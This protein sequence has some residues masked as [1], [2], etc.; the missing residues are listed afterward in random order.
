MCVIYLKKN[1]TLLR[2][3]PVFLRRVF[4]AKPNTAVHGAANAWTFRCADGCRETEA[5][6]S[7]SG[8]PRCGDTVQPGSTATPISSSHSARLL[9]KRLVGR[10]C[11]TRPYRIATA[12]YSTHTL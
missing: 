9:P 5:C 1:T 8:V 11:T 12:R 10:G 4:I 7:A 2:A 3:Y 6:K